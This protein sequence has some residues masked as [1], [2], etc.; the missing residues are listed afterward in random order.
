MKKS[1]IAYII[2]AAVCF[3][4]EIV[5]ILLHKATLVFFLIMSAIIFVSFLVSNTGGGRGLT[6][7]AHQRRPNTQD[8]ANAHT[9][10]SFRK[11]LL[12]ILPPLLCAL[13]QYLYITMR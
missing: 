7:G 10:I 6:M 9:Y 2:Y 13:I 3:G 12:L 4:A 8:A 5:C 11:M 1:T